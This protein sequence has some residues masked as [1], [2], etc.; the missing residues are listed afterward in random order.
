[1]IRTLIFAILLA[2]SPFAAFA[3]PTCPTCIETPP[4]DEGDN[5]TPG[6]GGG[7]SDTQFN[8]EYHGGDTL[9][10]AKIVYIFWGAVPAAYAAELQAYRD[11]YGGMSEH[12]WMLAQYDAQQGTLQGS[13]ADV[14]DP[15]QPPSEVTD[16]AAKA[17][18][19]KHFLGRYDYNTVYVLVLPYGV[20]SSQNV[21]GSGIR[22]S[23]AGTQTSANGMCGY[24]N[25]FR[26]IIFGPTIKYAVVPYASCSGCRKY[27]AEGVWANDVQNAEIITLHEVR[28][29]MTNPELDGWWDNEGREADDKCAFVVNNVT[30]PD[31][32][33]RRI[34][35]PGSIHLP[36]YTPGHVFFF[37]KE[38]SNNLNSPWPWVPGGCVE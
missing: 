22:T 18:V 21:T 8:L 23:C 11:A 1:M 6:S 5:P 2:F 24:H 7:S 37:Q 20:V 15:A 34:T 25:Y 19:R 27:T 26:E 30:R 14:F 32:I 33:F 16:A 12:L 3:Q 31:N 28:Q 35:P 29:V 10:F 36:N 17:E 9:P 38:W 13:Q 4:V